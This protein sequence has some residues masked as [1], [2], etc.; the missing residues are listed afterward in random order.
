MRLFTKDD[1]G[2]NIIT[3]DIKAVCVIGISSEYQVKVL[4]HDK[5]SM[6]FYFPAYSNYSSRDHCNI[7]IRYLR[8]KIS[9]GSTIIDFN[10]N[11]K[12]FEDIKDAIFVEET[13]T[14]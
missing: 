12:F 6:S 8:E 9:C 14:D 10:E 2:N 1:D 11:M 13:F 4:F 5:T 7:A 3:D